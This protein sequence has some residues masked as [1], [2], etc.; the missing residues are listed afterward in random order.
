MY[1]KMKRYPLVDFMTPFSWQTLTAEI[2]SLLYI[3]KKGT[4]LRRRE[5]WKEGEDERGV[6]E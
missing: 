4:K 2:A 3:P 6:G 1:K 5:E